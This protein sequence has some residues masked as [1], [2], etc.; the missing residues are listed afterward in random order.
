MQR[1][2]YFL[3]YSCIFVHG[4]L[5]IEMQNFSHRLFLYFV[6]VNFPHFDNFK[7]Q[8]ASMPNEWPMQLYYHTILRFPHQIFLFLF[9]FIQCVTEFD[10][11]Q[12]TL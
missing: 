9:C 11:Q 12:T 8:L 2:F 1:F 6:I 4:V 3:I 7:I 5:E 10:V